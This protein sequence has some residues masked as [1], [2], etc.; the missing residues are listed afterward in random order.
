MLVSHY[1]NHQNGYFR[2]S[3]VF[4][5]MLI[6]QT[7]LLIKTITPSPKLIR[8]SLCAVI[9]IELN[10]YPIEY[11]KCSIYSAYTTDTICG[12]RF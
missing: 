5:I 11:S 2:C 4:L 9:L 7:E 12:A 3:S 6:Q 8:Q 1:K 10:K